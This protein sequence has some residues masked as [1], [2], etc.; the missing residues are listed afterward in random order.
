MYIYHLQS[1]VA[2][3]RV[4][5]YSTV[6]FKSVGYGSYCLVRKQ[7]LLAYKLQNLSSHRFPMKF[8]IRKNIP[9]D[10]FRT[11]SSVNCTQANFKSKR[12]FYEYTVLYMILCSSQAT[13]KCQSIL[14]TEG[15]KATLS[16]SDLNGI[17]YYRNT[18]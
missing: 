15:R 10:G 17:R 3:I 18:Y 13:P 11:E 2:N 7:N 12:S 14:Y 4:Y 6:L 1:D 16:F 8:D 9:H 5:K